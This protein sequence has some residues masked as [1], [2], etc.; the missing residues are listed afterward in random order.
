[1]GGPG[2]EVLGYLIIR[3]MVGIRNVRYAAQEAGVNAY[4]IMEGNAP[5]PPIM[6]LALPTFGWP[7]KPVKCIML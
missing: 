4:I 1:M 6:T 5:P 2:A 7:S 3:Y